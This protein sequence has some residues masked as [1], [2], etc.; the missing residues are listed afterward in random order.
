MT[1]NIPATDPTGAQEL[2]DQGY[3]LLDVRTPE[4]WAAGHISG[5]THIPL[6]ELPARLAEV[7]PRVV[8][9]CKM[10]GRS[11]QATAYLINSG[12]SVVNLDGG[13]EGWQAS[14]RPVSQD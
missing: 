5:A 6:D 7:G 1:S 13:I 12:K 8:A 2:I 10:G 9:M 4:E 11:A 3:Q 14:G